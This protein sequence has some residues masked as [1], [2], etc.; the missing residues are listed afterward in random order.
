IVLHLPLP[1][2]VAHTGGAAL[3]LLSLVTLNYLIR[4]EAT[5]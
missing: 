2:A 4:P 3:L 1:V 5:A